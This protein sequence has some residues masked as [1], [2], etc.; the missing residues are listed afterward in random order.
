[1][2]KKDFQRTFRGCFG[3]LGLISQGRSDAY[4]SDIL[5]ILPEYRK[6]CLK[7]SGNHREFLLHSSWIISPLS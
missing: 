7:A 5:Q 6:K 3:E 4:E 1:M 2:M